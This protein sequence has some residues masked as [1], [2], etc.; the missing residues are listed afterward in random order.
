MDVFQKPAKAHQTTTSGSRPHREFRPDIQGLRAV[1]VLLVALCHAGVSFLPGGY[2]GVDVFFVISGYL[3]TGWLLRRHERSGRLEFGDFYAAR[4]RRI[5]PAATLTL[6][7]TALASWWLLN[8]VR[9]VSVFHD[10]VWAT[11]FA[12][13]IHF[14]EVGADYFA[15]TAPPS[16]LQNFWT[17]AVEEQFYI[18]WPALLALALYASRSRRQLLVP[19]VAAVVLASFTY[20]VHDTASDPIG[21]YFSTLARGWELGFGALIAICVPQLSRIPLRIRALLTWIG[22][23]GIVV[24]AVAFTNETAFPGYAALLPV[25]GTGLIVI[26][27]LRPA[28][29]THARQPRYDAGLL[30]DRRPLR[31]IGDVSYA[32]YLWHWPILVIVAE[33]VGHRLTVWQNLGLLAIGFGFSL[34]SYTAVENPIRHSKLFAMRRPALALW[35][36]TVGAVVGVAA[37]GVASVP[38]VA[39]TE[40]PLKAIVAKPVATYTNAV[41]ASVTPARLAMPIP[42][43]L[44]PAVSQLTHER[45]RGCITFGGLG[46]NC[47]LGDPHAK[48]RMVVLG[49]SHAAAWMPTLDYYGRMRHWK[50]TPVVHSGCTMG[51]ATSGHGDCGTWWRKALARINA[52]HPNVLV[53]AQYYDPRIATSHVYSGLNTELAAFAHTRAGKIVVIEDPPRHPDIDPTDCLLRPGATLGSCTLDYP[54]TLN[55]EHLKIRAIVAAHHDRYLATKK[56]FCFAAKCPI[57]VGRTIAYWDTEHVTIAYARQIAPPFAHD[58]RTLLAANR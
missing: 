33:H 21:A 32:F 44:Y 40:A 19:V 37:L 10:A 26:G 54:A 14:A 46:L 30:L 15:S 51:V 9:A 47:T 1:A 16:P 4:A 13:N 34:A 45:P 43:V 11:F 35:P 49:D 53:V 36:A 12:A 31:V 39:S 55:A 18:V 17:L 48:R 28:E 3:I 24:A 20:S 29:T 23:A 6:V 57:V 25:V 5:L 8:F 7:V 22:L 58:L 52:L 38:A 50:I 56:W 41:A 2:V 27:G 42:K